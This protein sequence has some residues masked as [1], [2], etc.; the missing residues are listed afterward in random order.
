MEL[1]VLAEITKFSALQKKISSSI[2]KRNKHVKKPRKE[3]NYYGK[4]RG[5]IAETEILNAKTPRNNEE[6]GLMPMNP[7]AHPSLYYKRRRLNSILAFYHWPSI[8]LSI[9]SSYLKIDEKVMCAQIK[10]ITVSYTISKFW[11]WS[12]PFQKEKQNSSQLLL[13]ISH[14]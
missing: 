4:K 8:E 1:K 3:R 7:S 6:I 10:T 14:A 5:E 9:E 12:S 13:I 2:P 11:Y